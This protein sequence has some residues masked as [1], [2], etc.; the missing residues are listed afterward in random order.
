MDAVV[1]APVMAESAPALPGGDAAPYSMTRLTSSDIDDQAANLGQWKQIYEQMTP[2]QF[3]GSVHEV[4]YSGVQVFRETTSQAVHESG[5]PW[6][7]SRAIGVPLRVEGAAL[8]R[9]QPVDTD[10]LVT[11]GGD[12]ELDFY[13][14]RGFDILGLVVDESALEAHA[15]RIEHCDI[16]A[17]LDHKGVLNP[18]PVRVDQFRQ[19]LLSVLQSL[20]ANPT[21]LRFRQTQRVLEQSLLRALIA[22]V[23]EADEAPPKPPCPSRQNIVDA[24]TAHMRAHIGQP[25]T[26]ADL[27]IE[28]GVSRRTLQYSFQQVLGLNPVRFLRAMRLNGVRRDLKAAPPAG[29]VLDVAAKWGFWHAGHFVT[30]YKRMFSELPSETL[31]RKGRPSPAARADFRTNA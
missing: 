15:R 12:D 23:A 6:K 30:D 3:V 28:L 1:A 11:L 24:A 18:D 13:T 17:T 10:A 20:D 22:A 27:C 9:G 26:V 2:G 16:A 21:A 5:A 7:G 29:S 14:P 4:C 19:L 31:R 25:I 8:F